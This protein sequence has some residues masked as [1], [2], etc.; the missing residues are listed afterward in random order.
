MS[1]ILGCGEE[2]K[3]EWVL[4]C[5]RA[6]KREWGKLMLPEIFDRRLQASNLENTTIGRPKR[7]TDTAR[8]IAFCLEIVAFPYL[9]S[10]F[11]DPVPEPAWPSSAHD[12]DT[13]GK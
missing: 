10:P 7:H 13:A 5:T 3:G 4:Q 1:I 12:K 6:G 9:L 2:I 8:P 11:P